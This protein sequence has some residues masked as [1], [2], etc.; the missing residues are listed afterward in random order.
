M[1]DGG[2]KGLTGGGVGGRRRRGWPEAERVAVLGSLMV[3]F[4]FY[5]Y[6]LE[7]FRII[8]NF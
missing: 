1:V 5:F 6:F 7:V 4:R 3:I 8:F 2:G